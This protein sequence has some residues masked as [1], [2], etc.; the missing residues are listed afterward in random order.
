[1]IEVARE[2]YPTPFK[3]YFNSGEEVKEKLPL[4]TT[5]FMIVRH[6]FNR[7]VSAYR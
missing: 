5:T 4:G 1:M 7:L 2:L 3:N 6:P